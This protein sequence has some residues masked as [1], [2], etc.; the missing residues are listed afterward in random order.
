MSQL[1]FG[2]YALSPVFNIYALRNTLPSS[3][4]ARTIRLVL[5][6]CLPTLLA[7]AITLALMARHFY[8][9]LPHHRRLLFDQIWI[10]LVAFLSIPTIV[11]A[12][13]AISLRFRVADERSV[14]QPLS[15]V[16][17]FLLRQHSEPGCKTGLVLFASFPPIK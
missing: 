16:E 6:W 4:Q 12:V 2:Q 17:Q 9:S 3:M 5:F 10:T 11:A 8:T 1:T 13:K 7:A 15:D 14:W